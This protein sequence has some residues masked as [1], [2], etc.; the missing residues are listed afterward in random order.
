MILP[1]RFYTKGH[2]LSPQPHHYILLKI[3][4]HFLDAVFYLLIKIV[5]SHLSLV[6]QGC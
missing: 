6:A 3:L 4:F 1:L 2:C 5:I